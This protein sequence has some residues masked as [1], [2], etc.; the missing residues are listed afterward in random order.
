MH[1]KFEMNRTNIRGRCQSDGKVV[2]HNSNSD[3]PLQ[4]A[5]KALED[6]EAEKEFIIKKQI[7]LEEEERV[8]HLLII[9]RNVAVKVIQRACQSYKANATQ[10][11]RKENIN[12][13]TTSFLQNI[14]IFFCSLQTL[15][16]KHKRL[17]ASCPLKRAEK[18]R[19]N[20][21]TKSAHFSSNL[22]PGS[23]NF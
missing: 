2:T 13:N 3:L 19:H 22:M 18:T 21:S 4:E 8:S 1:K 15:F 14:Y 23:L 20:P 6:I 7:Q 5:W 16:V 11:E 9:R 17:M 12:I 10:K